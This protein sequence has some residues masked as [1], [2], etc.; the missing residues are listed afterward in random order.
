MKKLALALCLLP[1]LAACD[2]Y[3]DVSN[4]LLGPSPEEVAA[5]PACPETGI[6]REAELVPVFY[7]SDGRPAAADVAATGA[8]AGVSGACSFDK[9]GVAALELKIGF[10]AK[11]GPRGMSLKKQKFP[12]FIAILDPQ[13]NVLQRQVFSTKVDFDNA[14]T[15]SAVE[16]HEIRVPVPSREQAHAYKVVVGFQLTPEQLS[17]NREDHAAKN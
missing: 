7:G 5:L 13:E 3:K 2:A 15:A 16:E 6:V 11:K 12:Y 8:I 1:L 4:R 10:G 14:E 17:Y 9:P